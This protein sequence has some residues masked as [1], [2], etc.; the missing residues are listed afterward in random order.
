VTVV[1][2]LFDHKMGRELAQEM[3]E[4]GFA[5]EVREVSTPA[6][7]ITQLVSLDQATT[8]KAQEYFRVRM[9][10]PGAP[11]EIDPAWLEIKNKPF[12]QVTKV[13]ILLSI[14]L[15]AMSFND[16]YFKQVTELLFF[17][18]PNEPS[19]E[20]LKSFEVWRLVTPIFLH[21][22]W[23]HIIFNCMWIKD[24]GSY[25]ESELGAKHYMSFILVL[26][27]ASNLCQYIAVG[28]KFGGLSGVVYGLFGISWGR[29]LSGDK[30]AL[31]LPKRDIYLMV[32]WY[33]LCLSGAI[34][35]IANVAHGVG[36]G[37][38]LFLSLIVSKASSKLSTK[39]LL[40]VLSLALFF[41]TS[42]FV[43]EALR[44]NFF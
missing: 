34:G 1:G 44:K 10:L 12:G 21:F 24:L 20:S 14:G 27:I 41:C 16:G 3:K 17:N 7:V 33:F 5:V 8:V 2:E 25:W 22:G 35:N 42:S 9:G 29:I 39:S 13:L 37:A 32:G 38:G 11:S 36:L 40:K 15:F 19:F 31:V 28:P 43:I 18:N 23:L 4:L 6:G 26:S 30:D